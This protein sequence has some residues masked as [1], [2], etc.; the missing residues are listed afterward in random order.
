MTK[1]YPLGSA[2]GGGNSSDT[3]D[4]ER[5]SL[6]ILE[7][8]NGGEDC[9]LHFDEGLGFGGAGG[10]GLGGDVNHLHIAAFGV[11]GQFGHWVQFSRGR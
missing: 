11:M 3:S 8:A 4:F 9:G 5:I 10:D 7:F 1:R 2:F 6:W